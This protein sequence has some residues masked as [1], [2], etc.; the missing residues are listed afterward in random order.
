MRHLY[1]PLPQA[2]AGAGMW[3]GR[4]IV[5]CAHTPR[6]WKIADA[7]RANGAPEPTVLSPDAG[8][9]WSL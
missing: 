2:V 9:D 5:I 7:M 8:F 6:A 3:W 4:E 1:A